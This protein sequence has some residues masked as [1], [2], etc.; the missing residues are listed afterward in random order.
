MKNKTKI[1][2][3]RAGLIT[4]IQGPPITNLQHQ[5]ITTSGPMDIFLSKIGNK[6]L[7]NNE[8]KVCFEICKFGP[9]IKILNGN[10][11]FLISG[12]IEFDIHK[13][14]KKI[15]GECNKSYDLQKNDIINIKYTK[16]SNYAYLVFKGELENISKNFLS[17]SI[18]S[19]SIG[20][21]GGKKIFDSDIYT[22]NHKSNFKHRKLNFNYLNY[23][24]NHIRIVKGPQMNYFK[25][26][27]VKK[28]F[29]KKFIISK[30]L[31]RIG[32][33]LIGNQIKPTISN[34]MHS[35][36]IVKG[37]IQIPGDGNPIILAAEHPTIGGYPKIGSI[38][39]A[40]FSKFVQL[41][42]GTKF[43]FEEVTLEIA[44]NEYYKFK[45]N[46]K[47]IKNNIVYL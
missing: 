6:I 23:Y 22:L 2:F 27:D 12:N 4:S 42:E 5:G 33:R 21:N 38:I 14:S 44:E 8:D 41:L 9:K 26:K 1:K 20:L 13:K 36:G 28:F 46:I 15:L 25:I 18:L 10:L 43:N 24:N 37:S 7:N 47:N 45:K 40:D 34:N 39:M 35:E 16:N 29:D 32:I 31:N 3:I 11:I 30:N 17:T 19:S